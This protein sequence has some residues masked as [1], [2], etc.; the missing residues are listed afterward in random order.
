MNDAA[1]PDSEPT[2]SSPDAAPT[3]AASPDAE[4]SPGAASP[5]AE[6]S[7][8]QALRR[9]EGPH[10]AQG[11]RHR[12]GQ[13]HEAPPPPTHGGTARARQR[14]GED[15]P[16]FVEYFKERVYA[17]FTGLAI[18]LVVSSNDAHDAGHAV[19]ALLLGVVGIT[20]AGFVSGVI[21]HLAVHRDFPGGAE[22]RA[23]L[24]IAGGAL[25]TLV[26][27]MILLALAWFGV[28]PLPAALR[29]AEIVY[30]AT[31]A[32]IGWFAVRRSR[33]DLWKQ[34]LALTILVT[35]GLVVVLLQTLAHSV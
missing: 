2:G 26:T 11:A 31:L 22:L 28:L 6:P 33:L 1:P 8:G 27:P 12:V 20:A 34:L 24:R 30:V 5:S 9:G 4:P 35:L 19:L 3:D 16:E 29:A 10:H 17:T 14:L 18:V 7:H 15:A 25:G 21:S 32:V 13:H 23:Q